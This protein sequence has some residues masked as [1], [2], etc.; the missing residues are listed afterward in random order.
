MHALH[1][2]NHIANYVNSLF[3]PMMTAL[4][5]F[6]CWL[7][8]TDFVWIFF[9]LYILSCFLPLFSSDGRGYLPLLF[10]LIIITNKDI[11]FLGGIPVTMIIGITFF[12]ISLIIYLIVNKPKLNTGTIFY[13][14]LFLFIIFLVSYLKSTIINGGSGRTGILYL[15]AFFLLLCVHAML[16]SILGQ[17]ETMPYFAKTYA[18]FALAASLETFTIIIFENSFELA[19]PSFTLGWSY[20]RETVS[21]FLVLSLPFF[22][23]LIHEKKPIWAIPAILVILCLIFLSTDSGLLCLIAFIIPLIFFTLNGTSEYAP[24][25][26]MIFLLLLGIV[27]GLLMGINAEFNSRIAK[28]ISRLNFFSDENRNAI[29]SVWNNL[30]KEPI[31]GQSITSI[32]N[33][34]GTLVLA[35]N[36][37]LSSLVL[38]GICGLAMYV[39]YE[40][41]LYR[42][43]IKKKMKGKSI[44]LIFLLMIEA[45][46]LIDNT[47]YNIAILLVVLMALSV[48]RQSNR[49]DEVLIHDDFFTVKDEDSN[50]TINRNL[51]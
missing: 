45:I 25:F 13:S 6:L 19:S 8:R 34:D 10:F 1:F 11:H 42:S 24:Y 27:F 44:F 49:P 15:L 4:L 22:G 37:I 31:L 32:V 36:T 23:L 38:G 28:A 7:V 18:C 2:R 29:L 9:S 26:I 14:F 5:A 30:K 16:N 3:F 33:N 40:V 35:N 21:S 46:G 50:M 39:V 20:T 48:F 43:F 12:T 51:S 47:I 17:G 41:N